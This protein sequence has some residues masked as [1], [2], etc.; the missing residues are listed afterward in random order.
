MAGDKGHQAHPMGPVAYTAWVP[1]VGSGKTSSGKRIVHAR[2]NVCAGTIGKPLY[3]LRHVQG[4]MVSEGLV[5]PSSDG[6][7]FS[8]R[9]ESTGESE[10]DPEKTSPLL[11]KTGDK[12]KTGRW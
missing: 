8:P 1:P 11:A 6:L 4:A 10:R 9:V 2:V 7:S 12:F 5:I 3:G